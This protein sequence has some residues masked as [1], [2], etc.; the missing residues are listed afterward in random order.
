[1]CVPPGLGLG[2]QQRHESDFGGRAET[3]RS[4]LARQYNEYNE[5]AEGDGRR[6]NM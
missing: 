1:M 6:E 2:Q 3:S 4:R 5:S